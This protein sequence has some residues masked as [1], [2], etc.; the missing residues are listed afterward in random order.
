M[1]MKPTPQLQMAEALRRLLTDYPEAP[2]PGEWRVRPSGLSAVLHGDSAADYEQMYWYARLVKG[3]PRRA[4][5]FESCGR[6]LRSLEVH[7]AFDGVA[8]EV[9][10]IVPADVDDAVF[11][12]G[13]AA[14]QRHQFGDPSVMDYAVR[15]AADLVGGAA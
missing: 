2:T 7:G 4:R 5:D 1:A 10:F 3:A 8:V 6:E 13:Q 14:E 11:A 15:A 12:A 9:I